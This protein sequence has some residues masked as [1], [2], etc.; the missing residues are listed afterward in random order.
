MFEGGGPFKRTYVGF[1]SKLG[2]RRMNRRSLDHRPLGS[3]EIIDHQSFTL[4][5]QSQAT[6]MQG[7]MDF[8]PG[9]LSRFD[10][11]R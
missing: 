8:T 6:F 7:Q 5:P 4:L 10:E 3:Q 1:Q 9:N 11:F 2:Q